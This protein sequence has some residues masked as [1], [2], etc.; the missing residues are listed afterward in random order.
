MHREERSSRKV[1]N[2]DKIAFAGALL[3]ILVPLE[4]AA[5]KAAYETL[6]AV[7]SMFLVIICIGFNF[8]ALFAALLRFWLSMIAMTAFGL[9]VIWYQVTLVNRMHQVGA[10]ASNIV[11]WAYSERLKTGSF[12]KDLSDYS[13]LRPECRKYIQSYDLLNKDRFSV[14]YYV[15]TT[16]TSHWYDSNDGWHYYPD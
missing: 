13:F 9:I 14:V 8:V 2:K 12:P 4:I 5:S 6:G 1:S 11:T 10:E 7:T 3:L 15:G 16:S